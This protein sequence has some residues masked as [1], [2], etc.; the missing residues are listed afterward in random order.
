MQT[1]K[2]CR[3]LSFSGMDMS[4]EICI[5]C[6]TKAGDE[7][8]LEICLVNQALWVECRAGVKGRRERVVSLGNHE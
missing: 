7:T 8:E 2:T 3:Q 4:V 5:V 1:S 6:N